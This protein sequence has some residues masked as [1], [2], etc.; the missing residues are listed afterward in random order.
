[1]K[2]V[3]FTRAKESQI[4]TDFRQQETR[5]LCLC[6]GKEEGHGPSQLCSKCYTKEQAKLN[7]CK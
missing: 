5:A 4:M 1:M 6:C 7:A 3:L 2:N